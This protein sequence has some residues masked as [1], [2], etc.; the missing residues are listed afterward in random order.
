MVLC[1]RGEFLFD[2]APVDP[3]GSSPVIR[4]PERAPAAEALAMVGAHRSTPM[5]KR[6]ALI[7]YGANR[8]PERL[9]EKLAD[10]SGP[11]SVV[12]MMRAR[13]TG[14]DI[15]F[16][17]HFTAYGAIPATLGYRPGVTVDISVLF[18]DDQQRDRLDAGEHVG[19]NYERR[20]FDAL[21]LLVDGL[22]HTPD[23]DAYVS[24]HG[25][26]DPGE[27]RALALS[28]I[29]AENRDLPAANVIEALNAAR[30]KIAMDVLLDDFIAALA[31]D[32]AF[33]ARA[34]QVLQENAIGRP[35]R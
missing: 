16:S 5:E 23:A 22:G 12:P 14:F 15:V 6:T 28:A 17:A 19:V 34:N 11:Q 8:A 18:V 1:D 20:S 27:G 2:A 9:K 3:L 31:G 29:P 4:G 7:A 21:D 25:C 30:Q 32:D 24:L 13:L 35:A 33:R 10:L 26:F